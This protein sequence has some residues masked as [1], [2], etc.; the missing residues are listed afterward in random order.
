[1]ATT[2]RGHRMSPLNHSPDAV[3]WAMN[4]VGM[5]QAQLAEATGISKSLIN[6]ILGGTRNATPEKLRIIAQALNC[7]TTVLEAKRCY[8]HAA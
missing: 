3:K 7:P 8:D 4:A 6:E 2:R 5:K 1:M